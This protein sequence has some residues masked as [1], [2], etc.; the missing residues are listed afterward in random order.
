MLIYDVFLNPWKKVEQVLIHV[1]VFNYHWNQQD[2]FWH[3]VGRQDD[4]T[5]PNSDRVNE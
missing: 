3:W 1:G 2:C 4:N 5:G